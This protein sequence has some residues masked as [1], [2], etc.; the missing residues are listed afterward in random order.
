MVYYLCPVCSHSVKVPENRRGAVGCERCG[1]SE[2]RLKPKSARLTL[3]FSLTA[4]VFYL[5]ANLFPFMTIELYGNRNSSTIWGGVVTLTESG[6]WAIAMIVFLASMVIPLV[7]L[8]ALFYL[9]FTARDKKHAKFKTRLYH[10]VEAIG[11]W[12]MLDIFL[13][14]VLVA[15]MK[16]G[17]WTQVVPEIGSLMFALVVVFTM[18]ASAYFDPKLLW[19]DENERQS[20]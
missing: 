20:G 8:A 16:L 19:E 2:K 15:I 4:L 10:V 12:S 7:K 1:N 9:S 11:R 18:L 5:P 3:A 17:P 14:A 13:L 6:S